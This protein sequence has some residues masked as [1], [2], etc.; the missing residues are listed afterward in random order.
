VDIRQ[1]SLAFEGS[2]RI[3]TMQVEEGDQVKVGQVL[4]TLD[5]NA[6]TLQIRQAEAQVAA[7]QASADLA[8]QQ[9]SR[10][11]GV[12]AD[13]EGKAVS[14]QEVDSATASVRN[15]R[16]QLALAQAQ[17]ALLK[18][19]LS[20]AEL[21]SPVNAV[22]RAR[23]LEPGDMASP[24]R[25]V[26]TLAISDPKWVRAYVTETQLGLVKPGQKASVSTDS[27][28]DQKI[29]G[30]IGYISSV[31]E[32]TPKS[33]QTPELRTSLVYEIR[34]LINDPQNRLRL[35]MPATVHLEAAK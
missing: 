32:F 14:K 25:P 8:R 20:Q 12:A 24:Q 22:V 29:E 11:Q 9:H 16:A 35:G 5:T 26:Y 28:P 13:T 6:L 30:Q 19:H 33:V 7:M 1:V 31:A 27:H 3:A 10:V 18:Y 23:L 21:I 4:A 2:D 34:I 15:T 17:L